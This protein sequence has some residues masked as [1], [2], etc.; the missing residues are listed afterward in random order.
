MRDYYGFLVADPFPESEPK[1]LSHA[2]PAIAKKMWMPFPPPNS[3]TGTVYF[4]IQ[5]DVPFKP[6]G[7][8]LWDLPEDAS[9]EMCK[10][11]NEECVIA[12]YGKLP[13]KVFARAE[14]YEKLKELVENG[15]EFFSEWLDAP[16]ITPAN[17]VT[18]IL[19]SETG[20]FEKTRAAFWGLATG[21][22]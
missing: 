10:I 9:L 17:R 13:A 1:L 11:A 22:Y 14:S 18:V 8:M 16:P 5:P 15:E 7:L 12:S 21:I 2:K 3:V 4:T 20:S 19:S 6:M